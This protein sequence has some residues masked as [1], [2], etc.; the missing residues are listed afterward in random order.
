MPYVAV[1]GGSGGVGSDVVSC[2]GCGSGYGNSSGRNYGGGYDVMC[3]GHGS[4][5]DSSDQY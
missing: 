1:G 2:E 3:S 5:I 4:D